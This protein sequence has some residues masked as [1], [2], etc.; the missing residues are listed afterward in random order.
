MGGIGA[1]PSGN[2]LTSVARFCRARRQTD[3]G[4]SWST[5]GLHRRAAG[6]SRGRSCHAALPQRDETSLRTR[7]A[8]LPGCALAVPFLNLSVGRRVPAQPEAALIVFV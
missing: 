1:N 8:R 7:A 3:R 4:Q 2:T 5:S 6:P